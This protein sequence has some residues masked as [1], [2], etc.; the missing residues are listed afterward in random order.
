MILEENMPFEFN[1]SMP[2]ITSKDAS[3]VYSIG[4]YHAL[5]VIAPPM[6][7]AK[8]MPNIDKD[9]LI[10][11]LFAMIVSEGKEMK[12]IITSEITSNIIMNAGTED[13]KDGLKKPSICIFNEDGSHDNLGK[14]GDWSNIDMFCNK[15]FELINER[16]GNTSIPLLLNN[17]AKASSTGDI[18]NRIKSWH[19]GKILLILVLYIAMTAYIILED[20][21]HNGAD[22]NVGSKYVSVAALCI[23]L[24]GIPT[25]GIT[26]IWLTGL[27]KRE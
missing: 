9:L 11:Y 3:R 25:I 1:P 10:T 17:P 12:M 24:F 13:I 27:E 4:K 19:F 6:L 26:W 5:L 22:I 23:F 7:A 16:F 20:L 18:A 8:N 15:C 21:I 2:D 14:Y